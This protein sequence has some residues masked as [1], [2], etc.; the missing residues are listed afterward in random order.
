MKIE[1]E[2]TNGKTYNINYS[3]NLETF[4]QETTFTQGNAFLLT[5]SGNYVS[6]NKIV[7]FKPLENNT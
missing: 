5:D 1:L 2:M 7:Q 3:E 6:I 4:I